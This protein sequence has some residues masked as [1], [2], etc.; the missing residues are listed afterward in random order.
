LIST[1]F[2]KQDLAWLTRFGKCSSVRG[3]AVV[4]HLEAARFYMLEADV[5]AGSTACALAGIAA[6]LDYITKSNPDPTA[7][8]ID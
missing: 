7:A 2:A 3:I 6:V 5:S 8:A 1:P 4:K